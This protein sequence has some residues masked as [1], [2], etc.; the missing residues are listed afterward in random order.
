MKRPY[1]TCLTLTAAAGCLALALRPAGSAKG[2]PGLARRERHAPVPNQLTGPPSLKG[3]VVLDGRRPDLKKRNT[4][5]LAQIKEKKDDEAYC[6]KAPEDQKV[7]QE[8]RV[9]DNTGVGNVFV[10]LEPLT[11][12]DYFKVDEKRLKNV[13]KEVRMDQPYCAFVPHCVVLFPKYRDPDNPRRL[14]ET[15]QK[16]IVRNDAYIAHNVKTDGGAD[17]PGGNETLP[18]KKDFKP[19]VFEPSREPI[20][21]RCNIHPWMSA[22]ARA[23]DHPYATLTAVGK[24]AKDPKYG[25]YEIKGVP[26]GKVRVLAWHERGGY[27]GNNGARG[28]EVEL[29]AGVLVK[30]FKIT[31]P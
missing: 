17:N 1:L 11:R 26:A 14:K 5:L 23:F 20:V 27:L 6:L 19:L 7:A 2:N 18:P 24:D 4:A 13:P 29:K 3:R 25:T 22:Y 12:R 15:G 9:G 21:I 16:F 31:A 8:W 30:D 10:W 28:E